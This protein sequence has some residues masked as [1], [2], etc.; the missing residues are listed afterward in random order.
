MPEERT[1]LLSHDEAIAQNVVK[2]TSADDKEILKMVSD[3]NEEE[4]GQLTILF[5]LSES[6]GLDVL[7]QFGLEYLKLRISKER[8]GRKEIVWISGGLALFA[9]GGRK[10]RSPKD[11]FAGFG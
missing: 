4:I 5:T 9:G 7:E 11:V 3:L 6:I 10:I 8:M 1:T 2:L